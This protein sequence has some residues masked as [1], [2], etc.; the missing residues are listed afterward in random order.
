M[1]ALGHL[2]SYQHAGAKVHRCLFA[3]SHCAFPRDVPSN[4]RFSA[5]HMSSVDLCATV[6]TSDCTMDASLHSWFSVDSFKVS[7]NHLLTHLL[8]H[9]RQCL[10]FS[11]TLFCLLRNRLKSIVEFPAPEMINS[12]S[13]WAGKRE[14][15][16]TE[17]LLGLFRILQAIFHKCNHCC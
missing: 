3:E 1:L 8:R 13:S 17:S 11:I 6:S 4:T 5:V 14:L 9:C 10:F 7:D 15:N 16:I 2:Y 12:F